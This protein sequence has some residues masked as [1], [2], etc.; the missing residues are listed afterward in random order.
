M[1]KK[2]P[3]QNI[4]AEQAI[5]AAMLLDKEAINLV[6][7]KLNENDLYD[8]RH[9]NI[10]KTIID[11]HDK[12]M[13]IDS[14]TLT[15]KLKDSDLLEKSGGLSYIAEILDS[16][17]TISNLEYYI[18]IISSKAILR[19]L[20]NLCSE[21]IESA[22]D[23]KEGIEELLENTEKEIYN[24][25]Q[26][27]VTDS[28]FEIRPV[29]SKTIKNIESLFY[30]KDIFRG[31]PSGFIDL[32]KLLGGFQKSDLIVLAARASV[33]KT[34]FALNIASEVAFRGFGVLLFSLEMSKEQLCHR[35]LC[36]HAEINSFKAKTGYLSGEDW[37][38]LT[39]AAVELG[40]LPICI[41]DSASLS[42]M[43]MRAKSRRLKS[44]N[45]IDMI[46]VDYLQLVQEATGSRY[47][48]RQ[49]FI[50][51]VARQL[52]ILAKEMDVPV[53]ALSQLSRRIVDRS[54]HRPILS[55]L[56]ESGEIEQSADIVA[57]IHR[58]SLVN[59]E[60]QDVKGIAEIIIRKHR[61]GPLGT[62]N[63]RFDEEITKF[64]NLSRIE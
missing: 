19:K 22:Y 8:P 31:I 50:A 21:T 35:M 27:K 6:I 24:V 55:D 7:E 17:P 34:S 47:E 10:L 20:I 62:V 14:I 4:D 12:N 11:L 13:P 53:I 42:M 30:K 59:P 58:E 2:I 38:P 32:D 39:K 44:S 15:D 18:E 37:V 1:L 54:D 43:A 25:T 57:F 3:P 36:S 48:N 61:N 49:T 28:V 40:K 56:R 45:K 64:R 51:S 9:K 41:D 5:I 52:K 16:S 46:I 23:T 60:N 26:K 63:L 33:G 29:M